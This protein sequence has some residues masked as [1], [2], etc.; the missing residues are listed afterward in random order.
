MVVSGARNDGKPLDASFPKG[1]TQITWTATDVEGATAS[2]VQDVTVVDK[3]NPSISAPDNVSVGNDPGL[4]SANVATGSARAEDNCGG[5]NVSAVRSDNLSLS[6][7]FPVGHT[8]IVWTA[9]DASNN[10]VSASQLVE[11]R[12]EEAPNLSVPADFSVNATQPSGAF[13]T[14]AIQASDNVGVTSASCDRASGSLFPV[15]YTEVHC[16]ARDAAGNVTSNNFGVQVVDAHKQIQTLMEFVISLNLP[17]G[18][19]NP[20][21]NQLRVAGNASSDGD[22]CIK[23]DD[24]IHMVGVKDGSYTDANADYMVG[25]AHRIEGAL[26]C[27]PPVPAVSA[28][29]RKI[30]T[31]AL[32]KGVRTRK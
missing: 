8:T 16:S 19:N 22:A 9:V 20:L 13:V 10:K 5:V 1:L 24:F 27:R 14:Y 32:V 6:S 18:S 4:A 29:L 17:N 2:G 7:P 11:V 21:V 12:D 28:G 15:G 26:G 30:Q 23:M 25:E 3:E 31:P